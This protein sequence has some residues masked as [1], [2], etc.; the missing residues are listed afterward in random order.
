MA[1]FLTVVRS[2]ALLLA[3][4]GLGGILILHGWRRW[5]QQGIDSQI[6]Y[7]HTFATP[8]ATYAAWGG[9]AVELIGG[10]FLIVGALVPLAAAVV[11]AEQVLI[12]AYTSWYKGW[13][14]THVSGTQTTWA[15][16]WEYNV[17]IG[18]LA[19]LFVVYGSGAIGIDRLFRRKR[20]DTDEADADSTGSGSVGSSTTTPQQP[21]QQ[22]PGQ[23]QRLERR[24][25][26][27]ERSSSAG[28]AT[29]GGSP[30]SSSSPTPSSGSTP[31]ASGSN[32]ATDTLIR[33]RD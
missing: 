31:S 30:A 12:V 5:H 16:G 28:T 22:Q 19:L 17:V 15:G 10:L 20:K 26:P 8:F 4:I 25:E 9:T 33:P 1:G 23:R 18:L 11:V 3:R 14:L 32:A 27:A 6:N 13:S 21:G 24:M 29:T 7:L 2:L